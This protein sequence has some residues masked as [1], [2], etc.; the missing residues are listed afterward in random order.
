MT[1]VYYIIRTGEDRF[2][3]RQTR[4]RKRLQDGKEHPHDLMAVGFTKQ[5][6]QEMLKKYNFDAVDTM[7]MDDATAQ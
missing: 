5:G 1:A 7:A 4:Y 6:M 2:D 3:M